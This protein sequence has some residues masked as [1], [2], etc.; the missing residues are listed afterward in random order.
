MLL[1]RLKVVSVELAVGG[2]GSAHNIVLSLALYFGSVSGKGMV[3]GLAY[4]SVNRTEEILQLEFEVERR[5]DAFLF[6]VLEEALELDEE[7]FGLNLEIVDPLV[8]EGAAIERNGSPALAASHLVVVEGSRISGK[9]NHASV[10]LNAD[11]GDVSALLTACGLEEA[12]Q[13]NILGGQQVEPSV[14]QALEVELVAIE[15]G[16]V[17]IAPNVRVLMIG[18]IAA[19]S[20]LDVHKH[21]PLILP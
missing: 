7:V 1:A 16:E 19:L 14:G 6:V 2:E 9:I 15:S 3:S 10:H 8:T 12:V 18:R 17:R 4:Y 13:L 5:L 21:K 20:S 11:C